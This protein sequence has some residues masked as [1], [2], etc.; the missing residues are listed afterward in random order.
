MAKVSKKPAF[1]AQLRNALVD[2]LAK[3]GIHARV[4]LEPVA[5]T[6]LH[7]IFVLAPE[8]RALKHSERQNLVWRIADRVLDP[9]QQLLISMIITLTPNEAKGAA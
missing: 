3:A 9:D 4:E 2:D 5:T 1:L 8:F 7:R 6:K